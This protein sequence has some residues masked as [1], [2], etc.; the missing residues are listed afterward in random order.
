MGP[1]GESLSDLQQSAKRS[2]IIHSHQS[3]TYDDLKT[4]I[5]TSFK[6][7]G[8]DVKLHFQLY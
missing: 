3:K 6:A 1:D 8:R 2:A 4:C 5:V 7:F